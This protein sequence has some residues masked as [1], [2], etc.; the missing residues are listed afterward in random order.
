MHWG[1][2]DLLFHSGIATPLLRRLEAGSEIIITPLINKPR[3][4][5][6]KGHF[7]SISAN[8]P[9]NFCQL[10]KTIFTQLLCTSKGKR[11]GEEVQSKSSLDEP[12]SYHTGK[13]H[14]AKEIWKSHPLP[15]AHKHKFQLVIEQRE[16]EEPWYYEK[17]AGQWVHERWAGEKSAA[18]SWR[19]K[20]RKVRS[21]PCHQLEAGQW[22]PSADCSNTQEHLEQARVS[23]YGPLGVMLL[24]VATAIQLD[25]GNR[26]HRGNLDLNKLHPAMFQRKTK[27]NQIKTASV[28]VQKMHL[29]RYET[30]I[31]VSLL[32][33]RTS[34]KCILLV[35]CIQ[36]FCSMSY[37]NQQT[38]IEEMWYWSIQDQKRYIT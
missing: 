2:M 19:S 31:T 17:L 16:A 36:A 20:L 6:L 23:D 7:S 8:K 24:K 12:G 26:K 32:I 3:I 22:I 25:P 37:G 33:Y 13:N 11:W 38:D 9:L 34:S 18:R 14:W 15:S 10:H 21:L 4:N 27:K 35:G 5:T 29:N 30:V 28:D 1:K